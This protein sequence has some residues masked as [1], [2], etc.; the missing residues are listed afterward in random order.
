[1]IKG[2]SHLIIICFIFLLFFLTVLS[3][4]PGKSFAIDFS[5]ANKSSWMSGAEMNLDFQNVKIKPDGSPSR[6]LSN[7][8]KLG[9]YFDSGEYAVIG[10]P[11]AGCA[12][13]ISCPGAWDGDWN[14]EGCWCSNY[15]QNGCNDSYWKVEKHPS[16]KSGGVNT[17]MPAFPE[18]EFP[19]SWNDRY[20]YSHSFDKGTT[21]SN[22][23]LNITA[24][25]DSSFIPEGGAASLENCGSDSTT[26]SGAEVTRN[27]YLVKGLKTHD[28]TFKDW[29]DKWPADGSKFTEDW[30][31]CGKVEQWWTQGPTKNVP[32]PGELKDVG[33]IAY[34]QLSDVEPDPPVGSEEIGREACQSGWTYVP[35]PHDYGYSSDVCE[36]VYTNVFSGGCA[37]GY[38]RRGSECWIIEFPQDCPSGYSVKESNPLICVLDPV[39]PPPYVPPETDDPPDDPDPGVDDTLPDD[40]NPDDPDSDDSDD[41]DSD[42]SGGEGD[43]DGEGEGDLKADDFFFNAPVAGEHGIGTRS[44]N[45]DGFY[46]PTYGEGVTLISLVESKFN[47]DDIDEIT[48]PLNQLAPPA[49]AGGGLPKTCLNLSFADSGNPPC[50]DFNNYSF[51]FDSIKIFFYFITVMTSYRIIIGAK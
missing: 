41:S 30:G 26:I 43:G 6:P 50:I 19:T 51:V 44:I 28:Q 39:T 34:V 9:Q 47:S 25:I 48:S 33:V 45:S 7:S 20:V 3:F 5:C 37:S 23:A 35:A 10:V 32:R 12:A 40:P 27:Y 8:E 42:D 29:Y 11:G 38:T 18:P 17:P 4:L 49:F 13:E 2:F 24:N 22:I 15:P 21:S 16:I 36:K 31:V 46:N 1:M 14:M